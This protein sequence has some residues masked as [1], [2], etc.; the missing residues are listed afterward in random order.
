MV[1]FLEWAEM[2]VVSALSAAAVCVEPM[3][4][5]IEVLCPTFF[6][7]SVIYAF[8]GPNTDFSILFCNALS[9]QRFSPIVG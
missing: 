7:S 2:F 6:P 9:L 1:W 3:H 4:W 5:G 8:L